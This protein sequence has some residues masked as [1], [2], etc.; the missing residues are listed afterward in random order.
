MTGIMEANNS[1]QSDRSNSDVVVWN[2]PERCLGR[3]LHVIT[4]AC[5]LIIL[6]HVLFYAFLQGLN[7][8]FDVRLYS[9]LGIFITE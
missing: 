2:G 5:K 3:L 1:V 6:G 8:Y 4:P 7:S 9:R